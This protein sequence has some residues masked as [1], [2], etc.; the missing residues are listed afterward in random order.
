MKNFTFSALF[1]NYIGN[2]LNLRP[3]ALSLLFVCGVSGVWGQNF[4]DNAGNYSSWTDGSNL[5]TGF[6]AW[7]LSAGANSGWFLGNP[8][9]NGMGTTGIGTNAFG[10]YATGSAYM[11]AQRPFSN[12][13]EVGDKFTFYW[14]INW[15]AYGGGKGFDFKNGSTTIFTVINSGSS[16]ITAGGVTADANYGTTPMLVTLIRTSSTQY[17]FS[18]T[19]RSGG[20]TYNS[21][22]NSSS[23]INAVN[24][25]IGNQNDG[26]GN[27]NM[28]FNH[29]TIEKGRYRSKVSGTWNNASTWQVSTDG[30]ST[31][32]DANSAPSNAS[33]PITILNTHE[34]TVS[35][36]ITIDQ[37][38]INSGGKVI[39][40]TGG[41]IT[42]ANGVDANDLIINGTYERQ[43][44]ATTLTPTGT[45][46]CGSGGTYIHNASGG[47]LPTI[48]WDANSTL[49]IDASLANNEFT[50]NFGNVVINGTSTFFMRTEAFTS[51]IQGNFTHNGSAS[52]A[53]TNSTSNGT[54]T[55]GGNLT[56]SGTGTL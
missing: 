12:A 6:G 40:A 35:S 36:T 51:S 50:E 47:S 23:A 3:L 30:G 45:V 49:Q 41:A 16:T 29:L 19:S 25:F 31:W 39:L 17:S 52:V 5:G 22:I 2:L 48:N 28:Y 13:M 33:G 32:S 46:F 55:I 44:T 15:D 20:S 56:I 1:C 27:R 9:N 43:A 34:V 24:F 42:V 53:M 10:L 37:T 14:S 38:T 4:T 18:M 8:A 11:N 26:N 7:S 21:T 54:L